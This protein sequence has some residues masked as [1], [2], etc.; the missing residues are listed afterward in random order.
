M[1]TSRKRKRSSLHASSAEEY[2][3][4]HPPPFA[5]AQLSMYKAYLGPLPRSVT[6]GLSPL[7]LNVILMA[8]ER[9]KA[10]DFASAA[11]VLPSLLKRY[12]KVKTHRWYFSREIAVTGAEVLRRS[13]GKYAQ[14]LDDFLSHISRDGHLS[15]KTGLEG[16]T[17]FSR[18][19][20][21]L[22]KAMELLAAGDLRSAYECLSEES[23][24]PHFGSCS[25]VQGYLGVVAIAASS[26]ERD[27]SVKLRVAATALSMASSLE[28]GLYFFAYY[29]AATAIASGDHDHALRLLRDF[30]NNKKRSDPV[31]LYGLLTCLGTL[32]NRDTD[33]I[34][35]ER[36]D[37][38]RRLLYVDPV[39]KPA[40]DIIREAHAWAWKVCPV[41]DVNELADALASRIENGD[42]ANIAIW[43]EL[44][45]ALCKADPKH[46]ETFW[47]SSGRIEWWPTHFFRAS[48]LNID[49]ASDPSLASVK[50]AVAKMLTYPNSCLYALA[51]EATGIPDLN[52]FAPKKFPK[53]GAA[54]KNIVNLEV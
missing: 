16:Y 15:S 7:M 48:R 12:R 41:V 23:K 37:I 36:I 24:D 11:A 40:L 54:D 5:P 13:G 8:G 29:A 2:A 32:R 26:L 38:A 18:E 52:R 43:T 35:Q 33:Q 17:A 1:V 39:S 34:K 6:S 4:V 21:L 30:V 51:A 27:P 3:D 20:V 44:G 42:F 47:V 50:A 49:V 10:R 31:A 53:E 45:N 9:L 28:P 25:L 14:L 46:R 22:E 19:T